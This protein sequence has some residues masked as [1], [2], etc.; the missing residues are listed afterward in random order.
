[1]TQCGAASKALFCSRSTSVGAA[2]G[3]HNSDG[4]LPVTNEKP[5]AERA[6]V[7]F[8]SVAATRHRLQRHR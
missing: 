3:A 2:H 1:M 4:S 7:R 5:A 6:L 8:H